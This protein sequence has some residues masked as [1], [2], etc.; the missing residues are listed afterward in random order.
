VTIFDY[1][2]LLILACSVI[3]STLRGI[4]KEVVSLA[5]WIAALFVANAYAEVLAQMM[6]DSLT[7]EVGRLIAAFIVLFIATRLLVALIGRA[8]QELVKATGL[9]LI[10][11]MFGSI[12]GVARGLVIVLALVLLCGATAIPQQP[13]WVN[14]KFSAIAVEAAEAAKPYLPGNF[15]EYVHF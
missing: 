15:S 13:F 8:V 7:S 12:F 11:R 1:L 3:I 6:P 5:G 2:V 9:S 14:A 4:V 10:D